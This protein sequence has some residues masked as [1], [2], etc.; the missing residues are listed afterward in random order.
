MNKYT[1]HY[2]SAFASEKYRWCSQMHII[3]FLPFFS[4]AAFSSALNVFCPFSK[5]PQTQIL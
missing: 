2:F 4:L 1:F 5:S 3:L